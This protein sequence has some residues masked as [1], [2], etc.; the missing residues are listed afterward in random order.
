MLNLLLANS[1][2]VYSSGAVA[3]LPL[4]GYIG[5]GA[6]LTALG[7]FLAV[8]VGLMVGIF[9]FVWY[10]VKK[11]MRRRTRKSITQ[12]DGSIA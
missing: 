3:S 5:P 6:G 12:R 4:I 9:G 8:V 7:A 2:A 1:L 10:P 11:L